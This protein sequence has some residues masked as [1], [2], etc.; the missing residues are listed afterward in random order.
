MR[1]IHFLAKMQDGKDKAMTARNRG[2]ATGKSAKGHQ[3]KPPKVD[4]PFQR[5]VIVMR[6]EWRI[7]KGEALNDFRVACLN[8]PE[9]EPYIPF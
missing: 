1:H 9:F 8:G 5:A 7:A 3:Y 4:C 2:L 6:D